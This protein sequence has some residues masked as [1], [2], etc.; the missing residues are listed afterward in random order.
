MKPRSLAAA[1]AAV[2]MLACISHAQD[3]ERYIA[4]TGGYYQ[5]S[6]SGSS[7]VF[8]GGYAIKLA[9]RA[10]LSADIGVKFVE[11]TLFGVEQNE[12]TWVDIGATARYLFVKEGPVSPFIGAGVGYGPVTVSDERLKPY[13]ITIE[14]STSCFS[15]YA[16]G[17]LRFETTS[18]LAFQVEGRYMTAGFPIKGAIEQDVNLDGFEVLVGLHIR[19]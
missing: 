3:E 13:G 7:G 18:G 8:G 2:I 15:F 6:S 10:L 9:R 4:L 5:S 12:V 1:L 14:G 16:V 11:A 19:L 17:G